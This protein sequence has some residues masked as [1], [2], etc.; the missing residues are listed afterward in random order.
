MERGLKRQITTFQVQVSNHQ[1]NL[2]SQ[3]ELEVIVLKTVLGIVP[4]IV[5]KAISSYFRTVRYNLDVMKHINRNYA[6]HA[7]KNI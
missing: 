6:V 7:L 1:K 4:S 3:A 2:P 5:H